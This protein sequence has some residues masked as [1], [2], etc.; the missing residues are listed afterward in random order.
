[1]KK[2]RRVLALTGVVL[3]LLL[4][5]LTLVFALIGNPHTMTL[6]KG[7]VLATIIIPVLLWT[8]TIVYKMVRKSAEDIF[9]AQAKQ[10]TEAT[11]D[12]E[13]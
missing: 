2:I 9:E 1:M 6:F 7:C 12:E 13:K 8:Y 11:Q 3:L 4:Y 10:Q 5:G